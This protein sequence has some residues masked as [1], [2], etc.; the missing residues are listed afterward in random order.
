MCIVKINIKQCISS[1][2][3]WTSLVL[4]ILYSSFSLCISFPHLSPFIL[5]FLFFFCLPFQSVC[6]LLFPFLEFP[7]FHGSP[8]LFSLF[9]QVT[10][11]YILASKDLELRLTNRREHVALVYLVCV[12]LS[13]Y[14]II[15][16]SFIYFPE[17]I[18]ISCFLAAE[19]NS[20]VYTCITFSSSINLLQST[21]AAFIS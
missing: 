13:Q 9:L 6:V 17:N 11:G 1:W 7:P 5:L 12:N 15:F 14:N 20:I 18:L 3:F 8:F 16:S 4:Y 19:E 2:Y 10:L 21:Y